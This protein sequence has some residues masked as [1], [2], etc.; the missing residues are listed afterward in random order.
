MQE[1]KLIKIK[2]KVSRQQNILLCKSAPTSA[3]DE[4]VEGST[5]IFRLGEDPE[6]GRRFASGRAR[7][8]D[9][10]F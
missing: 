9:G 4:D 8:V 7:R 6:K 2:I 5:I 3:D 1:S 10:V